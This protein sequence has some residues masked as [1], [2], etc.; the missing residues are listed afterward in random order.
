FVEAH[1][2]PI[3]N[4]RPFNE[5]IN[6]VFRQAK[7]EKEKSGSSSKITSEKRK[8]CDKQLTIDDMVSSK[9]SKISSKTTTTACNN[10]LSISGDEDD[11]L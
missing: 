9:K 3:D 10:T 6:G 2:G 4:D 7:D 5:A 11:E 8:T 1:H